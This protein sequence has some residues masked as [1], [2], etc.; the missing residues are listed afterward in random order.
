MF[1]RTAACIT[2][3]GLLIAAL[4]TPEI[5]SHSKFYQRTVRLQRPPAASLTELSANLPKPVIQVIAADAEYSQ[6]GAART[7]DRTNLIEPA[8]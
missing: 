2:H 8:L 3:R 5:S 7:T 4:V 1:K 6:R